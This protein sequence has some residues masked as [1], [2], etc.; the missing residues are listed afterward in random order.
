[1]GPYRVDRHGSSGTHTDARSLFFLSTDG[2]GRRDSIPQA[3]ARDATP[4]RPTTALVRV[5][6]LD[7]QR[8]WGSSQSRVYTLFFW[9]LVSFT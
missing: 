2:G 4:E 6:L 1:M 8:D 5:A 9:L 3:F 7:T